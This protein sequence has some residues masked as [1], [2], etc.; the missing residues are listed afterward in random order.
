MK[1]YFVVIEGIDGAGTTTQ[2]RLLHEA[3]VREDVPVHLTAEP[4]DGPVGVVIRQALSGRLV[5]KG[6][7]GLRAPG[8]TTMALLFAADRMDH[9]DSE[10]FPNLADGI[11]VLSDRYV[12]SS[13]IYQTE[14]SGDFGNLPW[15]ENINRLAP[16]PDLTIVL[17]VTSAEATRRRRH[18]RE[19]EQIYDDRE[20]QERLGLRYRELPARYPGD[21]IE[22]IDGNGETQEVHRACLALVRGLRGSR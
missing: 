18:R 11:T 22:L 15:V 20:L 4:S 7:S 19:V 12:Y 14:T 21:R 16:R 9:L 3:L 17:D 5:V 6:M 10:I 13:L 1:G 2:S 8:W